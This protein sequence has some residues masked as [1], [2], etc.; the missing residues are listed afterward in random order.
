MSMFERGFSENEIG[1]DKVENKSEKKPKSKSFQSMTSKLVLGSVLFGAGMGAA[2]PLEAQDKNH[3]Q[4][5]NHAETLKASNLEKTR[6]QYL[7]NVT[8]LI[9]QGKFA[10]AK[11]EAD[12]TMIELEKIRQFAAS[13]EKIAPKH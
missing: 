4:P 12:K 2:R 10:E 3:T 13:L 1:Q 9:E 11:Q 7:T 5:T 6:E 8:E